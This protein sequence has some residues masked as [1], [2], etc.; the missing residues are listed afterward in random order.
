MLQKIL[1]NK[2]KIVLVALLVFVLALIRA[3]E[4]VLFYDPFS[5][6]FKNDYLNLSFPA[7]KVLPLFWAMS[8][9]YFLNSA[10]SLAIIYVLF[11]EKGLAKL[12]SLLYLVFFVIL[13]SAFFLLLSFSDSHNNFVLFYVRRFL[14]QPLFLLL[15]VP[16]FFYQKQQK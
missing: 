13:I 14:I 16:A 7:F 3:F 5:A 15:F 4:G 11:K 1:N 9:R 2:V 10:L 12:A 6:Y 8:F